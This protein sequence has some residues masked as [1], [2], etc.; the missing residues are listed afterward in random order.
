MLKSSDLMDRFPHSPTSKL[1]SQNLIDFD[2][3]RGWARLSFIAKEAFLNPAGFIQGGILTAMLDDTMGPA[4]WVMTNGQ[5]FP[6]TAAMNVSFLSAAR[7]GLLFGEGQVL[8]LGKTISFVEAQL[9]EPGGTVIARSSATARMVNIDF[10]A[11]GASYEKH[12]ELGACQESPAPD[13]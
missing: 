7:P 13:V 1:F 8:R 10:P 11:R 6:S 2:Q 9:I 3:A 4:L 5:V 12:T